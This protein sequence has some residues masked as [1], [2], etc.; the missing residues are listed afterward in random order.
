MPAD[1]ASRHLLGL[2]SLDAPRIRA[3]LAAAAPYVRSGL[4]G[5]ADQPPLASRT[6]ATL[7]FEDSTRT[8]SSFAIAAM[9]LGAHVVD[10]S[11]GSSIS[12]GETLTDTSRTV[13]AMAVDALVVRDEASGAA[14]L[15]ARHVDCCVL[16][17]GDGRHEHPTQGLLDAWTIAEAFAR[18]DEFDLDGLEVGIVGDIS[19]SRVA[20][21]DIAALTRLGARVV[22][23]GPPALCPGSLAALGCEVT[24]DFDAV[25][26]RL[27]AV[28]MLRIQLERGSTIASLRD[29]AEG[30]QLS[31]QRADRMKDGAIVMHPG[32]MNRGVEIA[33]AVADGPRSRILRQVA[34]GVAVRMGALEACIEARER[35]Q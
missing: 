34:L 18:Q 7:F 17:A 1:T 26:P 3:F 6:V 19:G 16:N 12:K 9:R 33:S 23:I 28:Q 8:R 5:E 30:Y 14:E 24:H 13:E 2:Q 15:I 21:S 35:A 31:E 10:L 22:C 20:R 25:L 32:P 27:D 11:T 4:M 29:Y